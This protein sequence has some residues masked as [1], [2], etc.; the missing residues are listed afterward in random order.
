MAATKVI[1]KLTHNEANVKITNATADTATID[2]QT[3]LLLG[4]ESLDAS[5][6]VNIDKVFWSVGYAAGNS[7]TITRNSV[8]IATLFGSGEMNLNANG[9]VDDHNN[10][11]D[12]VV[13]FAGTGGTV[14][15]KL[16]KTKGYGD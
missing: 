2:L 8:A 14:Y 15:L 16:K 11:H 13:T 7:V 1:Q 5:Q 12:I 10:T 4:S 6:T 3:D 9:M